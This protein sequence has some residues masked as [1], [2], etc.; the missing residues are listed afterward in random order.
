[1]LSGTLDA[2]AVAGRVLEARGVRCSELPVQYAFHSSLMSEAARA[3]AG[4]LEGLKSRPARLPLASTATGTLLTT[5]PSPGHFA[6]AVREPVLFQAAVATLAN[7]GHT[8]FLEVGPRSVLRGPIAASCR[9]AAA[10]RVFVGMDQGRDDRA[11]LLGLLAQ[12]YS[13]GQPLEW[14]QILP[15]PVH[16]IDA[17]FYPWQRQRHWFSSAPPTRA[18]A[19]DNQSANPRRVLLG[20]RIV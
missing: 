8:D 10:A 4:E 19:T 13:A 11:M 12:L 5:A 20:K 15:G 2:V 18:R 17:P 14:K 9:G 6:R 7:A 3:L 1:V 16:H